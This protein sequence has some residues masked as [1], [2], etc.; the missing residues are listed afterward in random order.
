MK[1]VSLKVMFLP[2]SDGGRRTPPR[3][4]ESKQYRPHLITKSLDDAKPEDYLGVCF[5]SQESDLMPGQECLAK[6]VLMYEGVDYSSL[7]RGAFFNIVEGAR[8]V[9][10]GYVIQ[11]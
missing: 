1:E 3:L 4:L 9:G 7:K 5:I 2:E 10:N 8:L 11:P 6:V